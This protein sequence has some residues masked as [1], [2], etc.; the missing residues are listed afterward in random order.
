MKGYVEKK[1]FHTKIVIMALHGNGQAIMF[2]SCGFFFFFVSSSF[3][4][5]YCQRLEIGCLPHDDIVVLVR[6]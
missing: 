5:A 3:F 6:M 2:Y 4:L 1:R